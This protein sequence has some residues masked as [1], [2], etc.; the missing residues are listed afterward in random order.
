MPHITNTRIVSPKSKYEHI[1]RE[2]SW[3]AFNERV[4]QEAADPRNPLIERMRFL[5]IY[6]N[7][8]DEFF[9][10]RVASLRRMTGLGKSVIATLEDNPTLILNQILEM[11]RKQQ[12]VYEKT[13]LQLEKELRKANIC[14]LEIDELTES[15]LEFVSEYFTAN[16][17]HNLFPVMLHPKTRFPALEDHTI[18][19]S[20][21]LYFKGKKLPQYAIMQIP[22]NLPRFVVLPA[23]GDKQYV[24]FL[25]DIIRLKLHRLF[26]TYEAD[27][28]E[29][30]GIKITRDAELD[31]DEDISK[32]L[33]Q[34]MSTSVDKRKRG[35][36]VRFLYDNAMPQ[37]MLTLITGKM[38][39]TN[40]E[41][42]IGGGRYH[43]KKDL[44][45]F[46]LM[47]RH[48]LCFESRMPLKHP[49]LSYKQSLFYAINKRD[50]LLHYPYQQF[51]YVLNLIREAAIDPFVKTIRINLYR[52]AKSSHIVNALINAVKNGV[53]VI[54][55]LELQ[56]RFDEQNNIT[57]SKR[58]QEA[59]AHVIHGV[60]GLKV[61]SKLLLISRT[62]KSK[63]IRYGHIGTGNFH[64]KTAK[65]YSDLSLLTTNPEI[66]NEIKKVFD[67]FETNYQR[68]QF[69][70]LLVSPF[71]MRRRL[72]E[73]VKQEIKF[74][75]KGRPA[76]IILKLNNLVD[77]QL[78]RRLYE[79]SQAG[80]KIQL[81]IR[82]ICSL[83]PGVKG[84]SENISVT[85]I[86]GRYLE[87]ARIFCFGNDG[88]PLYFISSGDWMTR[89][90]DFRVEVSAPILDPAL[91]AE[92]AEI[93][94]IQL[95]GNVKARVVDK[96]L[97]NK[98]VTRVE[99]QPQ[100][101]SQEELYQYYKAKLE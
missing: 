32:S 40:V 76:S 95:A 78:I 8:M 49:H 75:S 101:H 92:I 53:K 54:V 36:Y 71:N 77:T 73:L 13:F 25:D 29:A 61:H 97:K 23:E 83:V 4:L 87:H 55:I 17:R 52:V 33:L 24:M 35:Q 59:G 43:N 30:Y 44:M 19:F 94:R 41:D 26:G 79:A 57:W 85:S 50:I 65:I 2:V 74:A 27:R 72:Q 39:I 90:L 93:L 20:I 56:A 10:V 98:Y 51:D 48:D 58:L 100:V 82:G 6:S 69:R 86:V 81:L 12:L 88:D 9:R 80:V 89:N 64:E 22:P 68:A 70:H 62:E 21:G 60:P 42:V 91:K 14:L 47:G 96:K 16:V 46:P 37:P 7:N 28:I 3:M 38:G 34:K 99:D 45:D 18:Y 66:T 15:Q 5:G 11:V 67:F 63:S 31:I 1:N 84:L